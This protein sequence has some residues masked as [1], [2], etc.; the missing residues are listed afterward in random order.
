MNSKE[1]RKEAHRFVDWMADYMDEVESYPVKSQVT[2]KEI[3]NK[4]PDCIPDEGESI[5]EIFRDFKDIIL[6]GV[7]HWQSPNYYAYFQANTSPPSILAEMLTATLGVQGMKWET[8]PASTELEEK[9]VQWLLKAMGFSKDWSGVI[10]DSASSASLTAILTAREKK[11]EHHINH[12]GYSG[13]EKYRLYC[14]DQTHSSV[15]KG[16]KI[17]GIGKDNVIKIPT[18]DRMAMIPEALHSQIKKDLSDGY[19]PL[20]IVAALGTT[21]TLAMDPL[22]EIAE[23][24][25]QYSIWLHVDAAYAGSALI[26]PE[27]QYLLEGIVQVDSFVFNPHKWL[28]TNFDC[29]VYFIKDPTALVNTF[30]IL[31]EYLKTKS[32]GHVNNH[33]DWGIP[34]GR[35]FRSLKLWFVLR[36]YGLQGLQGK[37]RYHNQIAQWLEKAI[38]ENSDFQMIVPLEMN[39]VCFRYFPSSIQPTLDEA[40]RLNE[41]LLQSVNA[42]G[43]LFITHTKVKGIYTLRMSIGQT[44]VSLQHVQAAWQLIKNC[45]LRLQN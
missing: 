39:L 7:T 8:S 36:Y 2:P 19:N 14:S 22:K 43:Q 34:L 41:R 45:A 38:L 24:A 1:F 42:T 11:S 20:C 13:S 30:A 17:A 15:E 21:G 28:F 4:L 37:L 40:N 23:I 27:Y 6:P 10:Q 9:V 33:C 5:Q 32:D 18:D 25:E 29:S 26:L 31:P 3:Y 16:A 12:K 35:R 44:N